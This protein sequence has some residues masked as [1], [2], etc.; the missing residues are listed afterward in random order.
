[1]SLAARVFPPPC[2]AGR[3]LRAAAA[4]LK[5]EWTKFRT[6]AEPFWLLAGVV[7]LT[8]AIGAV[9]GNGPIWFR[10]RAI[11]GLETTAAGIGNRY[12]VP[13]TTPIAA[14]ELRTAAA[15][16]RLSKAMS[17]RY[18]TVPTAARRS[19]PVVRLGYPCAGV[20]PWPGRISHPASAA[21][22]TASAE[23]TST[24]AVTTA[25]LANS[26]VSRR[27]IAVS[28]SLIIPVLYSLPTASTPTTAATAWAG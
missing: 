4:A 25:A 28:D 27:G 18:K 26:H 13:S 3:A 12:S 2:P 24:G 10:C 5:A 1:M 15:T 23:A 7:A 14:E 22:A 6:V 16:P 21:P 20:K 19:V 17:V 11:V 8:V 9:A